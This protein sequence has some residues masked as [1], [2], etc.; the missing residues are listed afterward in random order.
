[1]PPLDPGGSSTH[2][3]T[4]APDGRRLVGVDTGAGVR[5]W[6][7]P[8]GRL[9]WQLLAQ[10]AR[11]TTSSALAISPDGRLLVMPSG[12]ATVRVLDAATGKSAA[13]LEGYSSAMASA[14]FAPDGR[15]LATGG[16]DGQVRVWDVE[17]GV[18]LHHLAGHTGSVTAVAF[19]PDG[20]LLASSGADKS[21]L[22]WDAT[23]LRQ[24]AATAPPAAP[25]LPPEQLARC[26][27]D[28]AAN[29]AK[30]AYQAIR[31]LAA[32]PEQSVPRLKELVPPV[33]RVD[34]ARLTALLADLDHDQFARR[35]RATE[36]LAALNTAARAALQKHLA[37]VTSAEARQRAEEL[38]QRIDQQE[39]TGD[40]LRQVR[41]VEA[42]ERAGTP[43]AQTV[44]EELAKGQ[45]GATLTRE[46]EAALARMKK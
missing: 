34:P 13:E 39:L 20:S 32:S 8:S 43:T 14:A 2:W 16:S 21:I 29:D 27:D 38:L 5:V 35:Q 30:A 22:L 41:A 9:L 46:A 1:L 26:W 25:V 18:A 28:L 40:A 33:E 44:L 23:K 37:T 11:I 31:T 42:L 12:R 17:T 6:E 10:T 24:A 19:S 4:F 45:P 7:W 36:T 15:I 3:L